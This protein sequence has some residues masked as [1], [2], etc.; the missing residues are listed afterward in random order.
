MMI[1]PV[2][3]L[4]MLPVS[5]SKKLSILFAFSCRI[6]SVSHASRRKNTG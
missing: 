4:A 5:L 3:M 6:L 2:F 1:L